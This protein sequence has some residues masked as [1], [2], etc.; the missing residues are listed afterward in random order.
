MSEEIVIY[1]DG[2]VFPN[3]GIGGWG[4]VVLHVPTGARQEFCGYISEATNITAEMTAAIE[5]L[6]RLKRPCKVAIFTDSEWLVKTARGEYKRK[7]RPLDTY[8]QQLDRLCQV[9]QVRWEWVRGHVNNP[10]NERA[11]QLANIGRKGIQA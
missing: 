11:H 6:K 8:W 4:C 5:A 7:A 2:S 1:C 3:P 10:Y 9:H